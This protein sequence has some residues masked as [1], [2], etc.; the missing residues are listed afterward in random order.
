MLKANNGKDLVLE[1]KSSESRRTTPPNKFINK[2]KDKRF[3]HGSV[4]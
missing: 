3:Y 4:Q 1:I 2:S